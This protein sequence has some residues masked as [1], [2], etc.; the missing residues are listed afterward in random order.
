LDDNESTKISR[1]FILKSAAFLAGAAVMPALVTSKAALAS[2]KASKAAMQY[3]DHPKGTLECKN[4]IQF[5]PGKTAKAKGTC[6]VV[7]G[8]ISPQGYCVAFAPK[9]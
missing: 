5:I 6:K 9:A 8:D 7:E 2:N 3:Q 4:C 1:R